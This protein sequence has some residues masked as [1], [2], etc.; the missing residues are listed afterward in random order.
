MFIGVANQLGQSQTFPLC[1]YCYN[2]PPSFEN[3]SYSK[4]AMDC[5]HCLYQSCQHSLVNQGICPCFECE[6][7]TLILDI[8]LPSKW[9]VL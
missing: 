7:G 6:K 2:F 1:P 4:N 8:T 9:K 5:H 3:I